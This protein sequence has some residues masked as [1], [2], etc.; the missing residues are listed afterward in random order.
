MFL[1]SIVHNI[2]KFRI[3]SA[4]FI[5]FFK[6]NK[7]YQNKNNSCFIPD[8]VTKAFST[9]GTAINFSNDFQ[10]SFHS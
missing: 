5:H 8:V 6:E 9:N 1:K 4:L 7:I 3:C 10:R 2:H